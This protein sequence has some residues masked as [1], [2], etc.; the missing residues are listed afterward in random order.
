MKELLASMSAAES[1]TREM[2]KQMQ[3]LEAQAAQATRAAEAAQ[4]GHPAISR[5]PAETRSLVTGEC[6]ELD[7][8]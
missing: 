3:A 5:L 4:V 1:Q 7:S 2:T 6:S 8:S